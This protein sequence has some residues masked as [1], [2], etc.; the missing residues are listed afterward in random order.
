MAKNQHPTHKRSTT[1]LLIGGARENSIE[2]SPPGKFDQEN[3]EY[4]QSV[5]KEN[6]KS[7]MVAV[8]SNINTTMWKELPF[9]QYRELQFSRM[10]L[11]PQRVAKGLP[12]QNRSSQ[13]FSRN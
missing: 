11:D 8:P 12:E 6:M 10:I 9:E 1:S 4:M 13:L 7:D 2:Q 3:A 5:M